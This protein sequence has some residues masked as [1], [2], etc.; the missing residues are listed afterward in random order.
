ML[1]SIVDVIVSQAI[2]FISV[3]QQ[4]PMYHFETELALD[5]S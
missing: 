5:L 2:F 1:D 4:V 3:L